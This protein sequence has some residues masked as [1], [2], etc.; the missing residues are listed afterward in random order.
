MQ[1]IFCCL[2]SID[3]QEEASAK[4]QPGIRTNATKSKGLS[5]FTILPSFV[6]LNELCKNLLFQGLI[7]AQL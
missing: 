5:N 4:T 7:M 6:R 2:S 1:V 3:S